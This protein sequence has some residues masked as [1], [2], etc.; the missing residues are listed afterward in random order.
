MVYDWTDNHTTM[1]K[2]RINKINGVILAIYVCLSLVSCRHPVYYYILPNY[3]K[4]DFEYEKNSNIGDFRI[5]TNAWPSSSSNFIVHLS[6]ESDSCFEVN[7]DDICASIGKDTLKL[8][9]WGLLFNKD[10]TY[11][12]KMLRSP[13][14][15]RYDSLDSINF[16]MVPQLKVPMGKNTLGLVFSFSPFSSPFRVSVSLR[17]VQT[18]PV[19]LELT[20][21]KAIMYEGFIYYGFEHSYNG[22]D[23]GYFRLVKWDETKMISEKDSICAS[24]SRQPL[25]KDSCELLCLLYFDT[26]GKSTPYNA[27][28]VGKKKESSVPVLDIN[29]DGIDLCLSDTSFCVEVV[30]D[31]PF[32]FLNPFISKKESVSQACVTFKIMRKD[33]R[34]IDYIPDLIL[35]PGNLLLKDGKPLLVDTIVF[36]GTKSPIII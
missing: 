5:R 19:V 17:G 24:L 11:N 6:F 16:P 20:P 8:T 34:P 26:L 31:I 35:P 13:S 27:K 32:A 25:K 18:A 30:D 36:K 12:G 9:R 22:Y 7:E 10:S 21:E 3:I 33:G 28:T 4:T 23:R 2:N 1:N 29:M 14:F 15:G